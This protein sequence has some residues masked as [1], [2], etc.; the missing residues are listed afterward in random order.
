M[1]RVAILLG[2]VVASTASAQFEG[3]VTYQMGK[4]G[5]TWVY[6]AKGNKVRMDISTP[7]APSGVAAI[8]DMGA[9]T[10]TILMSTQHAYMTMP[11][12]QN[13]NVP[14]SVH[15]KFTKTGSEVIA[16]VPCDDYVGTDAKGEKQGTFCIAH[17]MGS[18]MQFNSNNPMMRQY[19]SRVSGL[20]GALAGGGFPL[21]IVR[22]NG[23]TQMLATKIDRKSLDASLFSVPAGYTAIQMP[24]GMQMPQH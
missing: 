18:F 14:D 22:S 5:E 9:M 17:G 2:L 7:S 21:K 23:E 3:V 6:S 8:L 10:T 1:K 11:I 15:G 12:P 19:Q 24:A 4:A 20:S 13:A 16:G